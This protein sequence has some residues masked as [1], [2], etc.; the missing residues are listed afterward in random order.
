MRDRLL[1]ALLTLAVFAVGFAAGTWAERH[2]PFPAP[3]GAFMGEFGAKR[4]PAPG[5]QEPPVNRAEL[6]EQI[7]KIRARMAEIYAQFDRDMLT[8]LTPEQEATYVKKF[9]S[10]RL[11]QPGD[12]DKPISDEEIG[13]LLERPFRTLAFF[14]VVPMTLD[15][16]STELKL[17]DTQRDKVRD[18]L[19][20]RREKFI[21][22]VD[23]VP[24]PSLML[25]RL[26]PMA[27]R[28]SQPLK[29]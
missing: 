21:E 8:V 10:P 2:R 28:L 6:L 29:P 17:D 13:R 11:A 9:R 15:R 18:L 3:P 20:V 4:S 26:A 23:S 19:R 12:E 16:M 5:A 25:S 27:Q 7:A 1:A 22:L 24:P 14:V